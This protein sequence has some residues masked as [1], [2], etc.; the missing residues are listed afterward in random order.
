VD[1]AAVDSRGRV[2]FSEVRW[3]APSRG[4]GF[5]PGALVEAFTVE[6]GDVVVVDGP[7]ALA[8]PGAT[9]RESERLL[10]APGRTPDVLPEPGRPFSGFVRGSV[11][12]FAALRA[13][14]GLPLLDVDAASVGEARLFEAFPGALWRTL[15]V[16]KLGAKASRE[17]RERRRPVLEA[18]GLRF[19]SGELPTHDQLDAAVCAWLGW[20][21]R[22]A[23]EQ[24]VAVGAPLTVDAQGWL[25]EGRIL[26]VRESAAGTLDA[27]LFRV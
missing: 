5:E 4:F 16:E 18:R 1:A 22:K 20:M 2:R 7:Q 9:V 6:A 21:T 26:D 24:V 27:V 13:R 23:L 15:A 17:G 19:P 25:R 10:R 12:L 11:L 8:R 14:G 3:P